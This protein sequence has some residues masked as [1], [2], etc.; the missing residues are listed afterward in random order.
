MLYHQG[1][2]KGY[3]DADGHLYKVK[4]L[5]K[6]INKKVTISYVGLY[7]FLL[8]GFGRSQHEP[9]H[10]ILCIPVPGKEN[11]DTVNV[12]RDWSMTEL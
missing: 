1:G 11:S 10:E 7:Q 4:I 9:H 12:M 6:K 2:T 5:S 8:L 3:Q